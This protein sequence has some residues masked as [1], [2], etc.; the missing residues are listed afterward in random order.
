MSAGS[1]FRAHCDGYVSAALGEQ[2][3]TS[4]T[5]HGF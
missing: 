3:R 4:A 1:G 5:P 2:M